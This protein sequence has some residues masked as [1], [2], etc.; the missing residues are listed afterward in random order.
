MPTLTELEEEL[1]ELQARRR[2]TA[3][4]RAT[5]YGDQST[6]FDGE[7]LDRRIAQLSGQIRT[8]TSGSTTRY[9]AVSK[10]I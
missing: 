5:A 3:G 2:A 8:L 1:A 7:D 10:G 9:A 6:Q 4:I